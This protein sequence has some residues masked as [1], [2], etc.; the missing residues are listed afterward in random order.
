MITL[1]HLRKIAEEMFPGA[2]LGLAHLMVVWGSRDPEGELKRLLSG[3]GIDPESFAQ[4]MSIFLQISAPEDKDLL[5]SCIRSVSGEE[6]KALHLLQGICNS[7]AHRL[8]ISLVAAGMDCEKV[9]NN[10]KT[11][12]YGRTSLSMLG[13]QVDHE[14]TPLLKFGRDMTALAAE[15]A[16]AELSP[17]PED[18]NRL[19]DVLLRKRKGNPVL[20]GPAGVGKT[21]LVELLALE[22]VENK[23]SPLSKYRIFE[24]SMGKLVAG[25]R[26]RGDFE[27][28]FEELMQAVIEAAPVIM[29]IDEIHLLVGAGRAEGITTDGANLIKPFL[30]R[31]DFRLIGATT[32]TEYHRYVAR[33]EALARRFQEIK[34]K[35]PAPEVLF[36]MALRHAHVL[37]DHHGIVIDKPAVQKAI[38][39]TDR[40][41]VTRYQPDKT[42]DLL[43]SAAVA[44][45]RKGGTKVEADD[46]LDT[47]S[48]LT[49]LPV[50]TLTQDDK[51]MLKNLSKSL[52]ARVIGQDEA[53]EKAVGALIHRRM[54]IGKE[55]RP[56]GVFL[57][58]GD[59]GVGKTELAR[60]IAAVFFGD[61]KRLV[62]IDLAEYA[63]PGGLHKLI[64]A[65]MGYVGSDEDGILIKG[66]QTYSSCVILLDEIEK[67]SLE[68]HNLLLGLLDNGR[69]SS[70]RGEKMDARQCVI[71]MTTNAISSKDLQK[72]P[73]GFGGG[74][75][76]NPDPFELLVK[77][78]PREFLGRIDEIIPFQSLA[79]NDLKKIMRLR[80][81]E[82]IERLHGK[83]IR[84]IF[85][86]VRLMEYLMDGLANEQ[87]GARGI[88][89][90]L[91]KK[92]LQPLA[93]AMLQSGQ[94]K[95]TVVELGE[96]FYESGIATCTQ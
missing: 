39:L 33:D 44:V 4:N 19:T 2:H 41:L 13:I 27:A 80:V 93:M 40:H 36:T 50:G 12:K 77:T 83:G 82:A 75:V 9:L 14:A 15:G 57:F 71:I 64:G 49:G 51:T 31:D 18:I 56:M 22:I 53:I 47:L 72:Q 11:E 43:D 67:A 90:L 10:I 38:E 24:I 70:G 35:E 78:F 48:R 28:R 1:N 81:N 26:Y 6:V 20:T 84:L 91:E 8:T 45:R 86:E 3:S 58:A 92:L 62:H 16:F 23:K 52:K 85:D 29:F 17:L 88:A 61:G 25:T 79:S 69:I 21:A 74:A 89:R 32:S 42:I 95:E 59:S 46:L 60:S 5:I 96:E 94:G 76:K 87:S 54:D 63:G 55:D 34:L 66:L 73:L 37:A 7:P 65:P 30:A 68:I